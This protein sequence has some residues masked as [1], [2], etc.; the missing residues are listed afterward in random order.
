MI[1][2]KIVIFLTFLCCL[3]SSAKEY[4]KNIYIYRNDGKISAFLS[5]EVDSLKYSNVDLEGKKHEN[6]IIQE[7]WTPDS[8]YR[9]PLSVIDSISVH[10]LE[11]EFAPEVKHLYPDYVPYIKGSRDMT[12]R[13]STELP[14][15]MNI[16]KGDI[17]LYD[18]FDD[19]FENGFAGRVISITNDG[20][21]NVE[22]EQVGLADIYQQFLGFGESL[23]D[24]YYALKTPQKKSLDYGIECGLSIN[25]ILRPLVY[26]KDGNVYIELTIG[27]SYDYNASFQFEGFKKK[28]FDLGSGKIPISQPIPGVLF[29]LGYSNFAELVASGEI[30]LGFYGGGQFTRTIKYEDGIWNLGENQFAPEKNTLD[31]SISATGSI[32]VGSGLTVGIEFVGRLFSA[33]L[34]P[35]FGRCFEFD[36]SKKFSEF[37]KSTFYEWVKDASLTFSHFAEIKMIGKTI[38]GKGN[39]EFKLP[40]TGRV[41]Y[42]T[43]TD[44]LLP[45]FS[46]L[47][48]TTDNESLTVSATA[49][50]RLF[51]PC[52][53]GFAVLDEQ[54]NEV[55][56]YFETSPY[57]Q[58]AIKLN[59]T[60]NKGLKPGVKYSVRPVVTLF[61]HEMYATPQ[62]ETY[63]DCKIITGPGTATIYSAELSGTTEDELESG[64]EVG[65]VYSAVNKNPTFD[66]SQ[67]C[68]G[69]MIN[70]NLF[71]S[72]CSGLR[73]GTT[74]YYRAYAHYNN[75]YYYGDAQCITTKK[76]CDHSDDDNFGGDFKKGRKLY[77]STG[78]SYEIEQRSAQI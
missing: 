28:E 34:N 47:E 6:N 3:I 26:V 27:V 14:Y 52:R 10:T 36:V 5:N 21:L 58:S 45:E 73:A 2:R 15:K 17:L 32:S 71:K 62:D 42:N 56:S 33:E 30:E 66:N 40:L 43:S 38:F 22:C 19:L 41:K 12:L 67:H 55:D 61:N 20:A 78:K 9:I 54:G 24:N 65:F 75:Q 70:D 49:S 46:D 57:F 39:K 16:K 31:G 72:G 48:I 25:P 77:V 76:N 69:Q 8:V 50:R 60:F 1:Y 53:V 37:N 44:Y 23:P 13:F 68:T 51:Q 59:R 63:L 7:V 29:T 18:R 74:Y 11:T 4:E 64:T 35:S